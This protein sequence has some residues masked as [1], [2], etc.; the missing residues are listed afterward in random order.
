V[1]I[2][3][4]AYANA[5][6]WL[7]QSMRKRI[8]DKAGVEP[9]AVFCCADIIGMLRLKPLFGMTINGA[10]QIQGFSARRGFLQPVIYPVRKLGT[11]CEPI[12]TCAQNHHQ[13]HQI[14]WQARAH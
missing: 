8:P 1:A 11:E 12:A 2:I 4:F 7:N 6:G 3:S 9:F 13:I 14:N 10:S 5:S